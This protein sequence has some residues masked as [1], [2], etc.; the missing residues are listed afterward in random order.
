VPP[1]DHPVPLPAPVHEAAEAVVQAL[2]RGAA[3]IAVGGPSGSGRAWSITTACEAWRIPGLR[4]F[5]LSH[6]L[7]DVP[8]LAR[9][10]WRLLE[11]PPPPD[12]REWRTAIPRGLELARIHQQ[13]V[14]LGVLAP[15]DAAVRHAMDELAATARPTD[16]PPPLR[17]LTVATPHQRSSLVQAGWHWQEMRPWTR[18]EAVSWSRSLWPDGP[19]ERYLTEVHAICRCW[20]SRFARKMLS[21]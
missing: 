17:I 14:I 18:T 21:G 15:I 19:D 12:A 7:P 6:H 5:R 8:T 4:R 3:R 20:T 2:A 13:V 16:P 10:L 9:E 1:G 11:L